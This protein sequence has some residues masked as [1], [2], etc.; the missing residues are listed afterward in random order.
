MKKIQGRWK[1][2]WNTKI[3][4]SEKNFSLKDLINLN[5]YDSHSAKISPK[6]WNKYTNFFIKKFKLKPSNSILDIGCGS[7]AFLVPFYK[8]NIS[9]YGLDYSEPLIKI[10][11]KNMPKAN[12]FTYEASNLKKLQKYNFDFIFICSVFQYFPDL[13]YAKK[14]IKQLKLIS[15]KNTKIFILDVPDNNKYSKWRQYIKNVI[16]YRSYIAQY[17]NLKHCWYN[18]KV[19]KRIIEKENFKVKIFNQFRFN[20]FVEKI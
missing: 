4:N 11:K 14:V 12:F 1:S 7:G 20:A 17:G 2:I 9:C 8:K 3:E 10:S 5:G 6:E 18:K 13:A 16:G 19:L 15:N